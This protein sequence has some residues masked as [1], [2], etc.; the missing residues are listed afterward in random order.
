[1]LCKNNA[2]IDFKSTNTIARNGQQPRLCDIVVEK[3]Y[4]VVRL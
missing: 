2:H 1:M 4:N 3:I